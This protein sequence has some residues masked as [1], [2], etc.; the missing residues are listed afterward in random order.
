[1]QSN[2]QNSLRREHYFLSYRY[3]FKGISQVILIENAI[4]GF[5]ILIAITIFS[6]YL[7]II[8]LLSSIIGPL[9]GKMGAQMKRVLI[10]VY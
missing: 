6:Y 2:K 1:M 9:V 3:L 5:I 8:A 10:K 4:T 7:G